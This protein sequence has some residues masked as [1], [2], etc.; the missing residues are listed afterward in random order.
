MN[1]PAFVLMSLIVLVV[2]IAISA[3]SAALSH[4]VRKGADLQEQSDLTI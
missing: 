3:V 4:L 1:H 2:G